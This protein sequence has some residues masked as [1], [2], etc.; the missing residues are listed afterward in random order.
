MTF[1]T[2]FVAAAA[3]TLLAGCGETDDNDEQTRSV[4]ELED[5]VCVHATE[6]AHER[7]ASLDIDDV[8]IEDDNIGETHRHF[9][10]TLQQAED[11]DDYQGYVAF[12]VSDHDADEFGIFTGADVELTLFDDQGEPLDEQPT[13]DDFDACAEIAQQHSIPLSPALYYVYFEPG[14]TETIST[15]TE[16][17]DDVE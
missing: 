1:R 9:R 3:I 11:D 17:L 6:R 5:E 7:D 2:I 13:V 4:E 16:R 14:D 8:D 12:D 10:T 15:V